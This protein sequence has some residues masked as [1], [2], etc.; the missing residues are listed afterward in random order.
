MQGVLESLDKGLEAQLKELDERVAR[1][2]RSYRCRC[3][4]RIFFRNTLCL[5]CKSQLGYLPNLAVFA[6]DQ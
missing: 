1:H 3:A 5:A 6:L 4:N 2:A